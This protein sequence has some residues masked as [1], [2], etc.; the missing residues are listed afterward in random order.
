[1]LR[2]VLPPS[3]RSHGFTLAEILALLFFLSSIFFVLGVS[4]SSVARSLAM[5]QLNSKAHHI[6]QKLASRIRS[7]VAGL[8]QGAYYV[9][10]LPA[11]SSINCSDNVCTAKE[12]A[13]SDLAEI[14]QL[15][16]TNLPSA[17]LQVQKVFGKVIQIRMLWDTDQNKINGSGCQNS[18]AIVMSCAIV[19]VDVEGFS[20]N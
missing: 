7:N 15:A 10:G 8:E 17:E 1:M 9:N 12:L 16:Q 6:A 19:N 2:T 14:F 3:R 4:D 13:V 20:L 5:G 18:K 11:H